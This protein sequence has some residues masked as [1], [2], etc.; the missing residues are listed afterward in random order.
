MWY[1]NGQKMEEG[2]MKNGREY[3]KWMYYKQDGKIDKE[4][5]HD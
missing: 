4:L 5:V 1:G 2:I 3:G